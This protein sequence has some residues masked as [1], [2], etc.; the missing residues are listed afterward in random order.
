MGAGEGAVWG[1]GRRDEGTVVILQRQQIPLNANI[2]KWRKCSVS[3]SIYCLSGSK[4][5]PFGACSINR[6]KEPVFFLWR[7][8]QS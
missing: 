1:G 3:V 8:A 6:E 7:L 5:P 4:F 2:E